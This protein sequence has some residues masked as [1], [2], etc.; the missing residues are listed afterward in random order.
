MGKISDGI[1][2]QSRL[3]TDGE[4][5]G[6]EFRVITFLFLVLCLKGH[7]PNSYINWISGPLNFTIL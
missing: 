4:E 5:T 7:L 2:K 3:A 6:P 1:Y